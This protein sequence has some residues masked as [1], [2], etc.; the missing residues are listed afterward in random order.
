MTHESA[1]AVSAP[2]TPSRR[3]RHPAVSA[4]ARQAFLEA[5]SAGWSVTHAAADAGAHRRRFYDLRDADANFGAEWD[6]AIVM[7]TE[8]LE[9]EA[10]RRAVDGWDEPV[11]QKGE[12]VGHIRRYDSAL[13]QF[14]LKK[15]DPSFRE[16][17]RVEVTGARGGP[18][19]VAA[20][21]QPPTLADVVRLAG[22]LGVLDS[23]GFTLTETVDGE[24]VE[25]A[26]DLEAGDA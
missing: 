21:Y 7:G 12:L 26:G 3:R 13:I 5:L 8:A 25:I 4:A 20:G 17:A 23:M 10:R 18:V 22:E 9:D 2:S 16:N 14:L 15:R 11:Y 1:A 6:E 19:E 24:A